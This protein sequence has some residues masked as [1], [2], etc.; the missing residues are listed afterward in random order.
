MK[1]FKN[2]MRIKI[3]N[4][5]HPLHGKFG[6]VVR[7]RFSDNM[8]WVEMDHREHNNLELFPFPVDDP[9]TNLTLLAPEECSKANA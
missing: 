6:T 5:D 3:T 9:R 1:R 4:T 2:H 8:A 7:L